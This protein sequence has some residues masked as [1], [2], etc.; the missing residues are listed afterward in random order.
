[1]YAVSKSSICSL[2]LSQNNFE[3]RRANHYMLMKGSVEIGMFGEFASGGLYRRIASGIRYTE[4]N[5][6]A[7]TQAR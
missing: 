7:T 3:Q 6:C 4:V 5:H 1:M 2:H